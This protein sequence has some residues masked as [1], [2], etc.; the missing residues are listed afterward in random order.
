[1]FPWSS[2]M[3]VLES[4]QVIGLRLLKFALGGPE[5]EFEANLMWTEKIAAS[6]EA[7]VTLCQSSNISMVVDRYRQHVAANVARLTA[8]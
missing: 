3:L 6:L 2:A 7:G 4:S 5:A 8:G 1:M